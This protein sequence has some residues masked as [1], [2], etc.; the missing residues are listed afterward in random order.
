MNSPRTL[1]FCLLSLA[2]F[3]AACS[4]PESRISKDQAIFDSL[5]PATQQKIRA[6]Q[7]DVGFT[8]QMVKLALGEP[9]GAFNRTT[10]EGSEEIWTYRD[11]RPRMSFGF[12][13]AGGGGGTSVGTGVG[14][15]SGGSRGDRMTVIFRGGQVAVIQTRQR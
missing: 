4:T 5:P 8:P 13:I 3:L 15:S 11:H 10:S 12:G 7:V 1:W 14:V 2:F 9:D 6:G